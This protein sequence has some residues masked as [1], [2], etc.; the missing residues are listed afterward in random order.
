M[1]ISTIGTTLN[2]LETVF[3]DQFKGKFRDTNI[4]NRLKI[5]ALYKASILDQHDDI[6][7]VEL[8]QSLHVPS[9][10]DYTQ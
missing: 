6:E 3:P 10:I 2:K 4:G 9:D 1:G 5:E 8:D 7:Q